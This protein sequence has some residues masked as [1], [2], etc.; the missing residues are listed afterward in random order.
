MPTP[1]G[2]AK[3]RPYLSNGQVLQALVLLFAGDVTA[4]NLVDDFNRPPLTARV[5][6]FAND[7]YNFLGLYVTTLFSVRAMSV[8]KQ[9]LYR[10]YGKSCNS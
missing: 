9:S 1:A 7:T 5:R 8:P 2:P 10:A 4:L 3:P 6:H